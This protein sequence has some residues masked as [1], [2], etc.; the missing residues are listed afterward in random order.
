[1]KD[2]G[3]WTEED[4]REL[5]EIVAK[6]AVLQI[7]LQAAQKRGDDDKCLAVAKEM[8]D[9]RR[10]MWELFLVQ[11]TVYMNSAE[12]VSE[13]IK[14]EAVMAACTVVQ[15]T[16]ER[17]WQSYKDFVEE[18]DFNLKSTVHPTVVTL[19]AKILDDLRQGVMDDY[20]EKQYLKSVEASMLDPE[21]EEKV[22]AK[23]KERASIA[24]EELEEKES[25]EGMETEVSQT[26]G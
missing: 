24:L 14:L 13:A 3:M 12:G 8:S 23:L 2:H 15:S 9:N 20:P 4:D 18:R 22:I 10:R 19:Q 16:G 6:I 25:A 21:L 11:Q 26:E 7:E 1:M 5:R 17:Y